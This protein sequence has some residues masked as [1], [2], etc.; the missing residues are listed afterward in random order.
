MK[1]I[2]ALVNPAA[3]SLLIHTFVFG[4]AA[5]WVF[6]V[7]EITAAF[8]YFYEIRGREAREESERIEKLLLDFNTDDVT[9]LAIETEEGRIEIARSDDGW[10]ILQPHALDA[11]AAAVDRLLSRKDGS[12]R[13]PRTL[14]P[15]ASTIH[16]FPSPSR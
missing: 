13:M 9:N 10:R 4:W 6:F 14:P 7:V 11:D 1:L 12:W 15:S 3:T 5:E 8:V 16:R 2:I